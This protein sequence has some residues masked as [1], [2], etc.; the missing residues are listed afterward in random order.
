[1]AD[2]T[3]VPT[4]EGWLY[5]AG[6]MDLSTR[7]IVGW[8]ADSRMTK[9]LALRAL[10]MAIRREQPTNPVIHPPDR[11]SQYASHAYPDKLQKYGVIPGM[12]RKGN[13][14]TTT[15]TWSRSTAF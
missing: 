4:D 11:G 12:S 13:S 14:A 5:L 2:I 9:A 6:I 1:V 8:H 3:Y 7:K 15:P 10:D